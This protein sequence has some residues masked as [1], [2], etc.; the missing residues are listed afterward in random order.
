MKVGTDAILL[1]CLTEVQNSESNILDVGTGCGV[2]AL[3]I[4]Q[5]FSQVKIEAIDIDKFASEEANYNFGR[6]PWSD[7]VSVGNIS[8]QDFSYEMQDPFDHI[9]SNPPFF[10]GD[11]LSVFPSRTK[12]R[13][14]VYLS[15]K[16]F[17]DAAFR[18][19][20]EESK[21]SVIL[22]TM[23]EE[24]FVQLAS[25]RSF[26]LVRKISIRPKAKKS[27]NRVVLSF[28]RRFDVLQTDSLIIYDSN[29]SYSKDYKRITSDFLI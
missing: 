8:F 23:I 21:L 18:L 12:S 15:H 5:R 24:N 11:K 25:Q 17:V 13:H 10:S 22:P 28:S 1:G 19:S 27:A 7:R 4:A 26:N 3:M 6:S 16:D 29:G 2:I 20:H 14:T 9:I